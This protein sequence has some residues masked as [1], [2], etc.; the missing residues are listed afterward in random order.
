[1]AVGMGTTESAVILAMP[2]N[3][4]RLHLRPAFADIAAKFSLDI[5]PAHRLPREAGH[6]VDLARDAAAIG[7]GHPGE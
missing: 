2:A 3:G 7:L 5:S 1:M 4:I 6:V